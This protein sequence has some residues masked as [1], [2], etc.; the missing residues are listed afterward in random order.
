MRITD[1]KN[2]SIQEI[3]DFFEKE[4][5]VDRSMLLM[6]AL[7][8]TKAK[9]EI[10]DFLVTVTSDMVPAPNI[11]KN[12]DEYKYKIVVRDNELYL[13]IQIVSLPEF[14]PKIYYY[15]T[16]TENNHWVHPIDPKY[17]KLYQKLVDTVGDKAPIE[18]KNFFIL[19]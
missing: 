3:Y 12:E 16:L 2:P 5:K 19:N 9:V 6:Q 18:I 15:C 7:E 17:T 11:Y 8:S 13:G 14:S 4:M 10:S 1:L